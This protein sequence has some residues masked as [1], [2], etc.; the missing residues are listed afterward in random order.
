MAI[1]LLWLFLIGFI[2]GSVLIL[3]A[4][5]KYARDDAPDL[6][7]TNPLSPFL[8]KRH[9]AWF[10]PPGFRVHLIGVILVHLGLLSNVVYWLFAS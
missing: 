4:R 1:I 8:L 6:F 5:S 9:R 10:H 7:D 3:T 2:G